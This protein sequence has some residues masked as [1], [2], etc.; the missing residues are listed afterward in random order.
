MFRLLFTLVVGLFCGLPALDARAEALPHTLGYSFYVQGQPAGRADITVTRTPK[1]LVFD[2]RTRV[3]INYNVLAL[4]SHTVADPKTFLIR[5]FTLKGTKGDLPVSC[6]AHLRA[7][8]AYGYVENNGQLADKRIKMPLTPT[9]MFEDWVV[10]HEILMAL[11]Q[12][13]A[14]EK[15]KTYGLLFPSSFTPTTITLGYSGDVLVEAGARSMTARKLVII[16]QGAQPYESR[17]D[18]KT[19]VPVYI[20]FPESQTEMFLDTIFGEN[21]ISYYQ[22]TGKKQ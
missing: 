21:P 18:P 9:L 3:I 16:I 6:E 17:V 13:H 22:T 5:D 2:S 1:A 11:A 15:T 20:R 10:E 8:S 12:A 14:T 7:D 19:G 4:T